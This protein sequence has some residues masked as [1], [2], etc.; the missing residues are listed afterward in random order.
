M[1]PLVNIQK[2]HPHQSLQVYSPFCLPLSA[3]RWYV[4]CEGEIPQ[5][6]RSLCDALHLDWAIIKNSAEGS[7]TRSDVKSNKRRERFMITFPEGSFGTVPNLTETSSPPTYSNQHTEPPKKR[8][9]FDELGNR[10]PF[11]FSDC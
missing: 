8:M 4:T 10:P 5:F 6:L 9:M 1:R 3:A 2:H 11:D 7:S